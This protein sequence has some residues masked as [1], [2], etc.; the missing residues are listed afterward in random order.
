[1]LNLL[2]YFLKEFWKDLVVPD[3]DTIID[4]MEVFE[5]FIAVLEK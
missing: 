5:N 3:K 1:M 4:D 2:K